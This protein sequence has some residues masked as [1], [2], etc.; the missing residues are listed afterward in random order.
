MFYNR[1]SDCLG[2]SLLLLIYLP[3]HLFLP[4][5]YFSGYQSLR[6][7]PRFQPEVWVLPSVDRLPWS[8]W[9]VFRIFSGVSANSLLLCC[10][11]LLS[12]YHFVSSA[13]TTAGWTMICL[14]DVV[15]CLPDWTSFCCT[16]WYPILPVAGTRPTFWPLLPLPSLICSDL[17]RVIGNWPC[18]YAPVI[19]Q[20]ASLITGLF[21]YEMWPYE[22]KGISSLWWWLC[23][24]STTGSSPWEKHHD[25]LSTLQYYF[26][27]I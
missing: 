7:C 10:A 26:G 24:V 9:C 14:L 19:K 4:C 23:Q 2:S 11:H 1:P 21:N 15:L 25:Q 12:Q 5:F 13:F 3:I 27:S 20:T 8:L 16:G 18:S 22:K 6:I 17:N